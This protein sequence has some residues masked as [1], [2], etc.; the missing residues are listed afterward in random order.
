[1]D[2][3]SRA[4][5]VVAVTLLVLAI[6]F[7][8]VLLVLR[9]S[10]VTI[11]SSTNNPSLSRLPTVAVSPSPS[12]SGVT[13]APTTSSSANKTFIGQGFNLNYPTS[14]G[15]LTCNN[16][17]NFEFDPGN[18]VDAKNVICDIAVKSITV[19]VTTT[20]PNCQGDKVKLGNNDVIR[21]KVISD[22]GNI[23]YRWCLAVGG[24]GFDIT[25]RVSQSGGRATSKI[26][27]SAQVEQMIGTIKTTPAGS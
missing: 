5:I 24:K 25:H 10:K 14:W 19:L 13:L 9:A 20:Q 15:I 11:P 18:S 23:N 12:A 8:V 17:Q 7:V 3:R 16:S 22:N 26:D 1:M 2:Q 27:F 6:I 4:I 21:S